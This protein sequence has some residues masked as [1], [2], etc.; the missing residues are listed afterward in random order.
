MAEQQSEESADRARSA[1]N[2]GK[3]P[4][5]N[6]TRNHC[7]AST[8][9]SA[10]ARSLR[11]LLN[12]LHQNIADEWQEGF[13]HVLQEEITRSFSKANPVQGS[14]RVVEPE[15]L[16]QENRLRKDGNQVR[17]IYYRK[18]GAPYDD[19]PLVLEIKVANLRVKRVLVDT[20]SSSDIISLQ[21]LQK[22]KHDA[23]A[24]EKVF[25]PLVG[26]EGSVVCPTASILL[27]VSIGTPPVTKE[28]VTRFTIVASLTSF[29]IILG[30]PAL[31]D[32]KAVIVPHLLQV[33][34]VGSNGRNGAL[35]GNQQLARDCY[36]TTLE[37]ASWG[38]SPKKNEKLKPLKSQ[39]KLKETPMAH[40]ADRRPKLVGEHYDIF[41][42]LTDPS[43]TVPI[44]IPPDDPMAAVLVQ[45]LRE[46]KEIFAF[47]VEEMPDINPAVAVHKLNVDSAMKPVRQK[48]RNHGEARNLAAAA[49]VQKLMDAS[50]IR[51]CQYPD[52]V[53]NVVLVPNPNG[54]WRMCVD[55]TDLNKACPKDSFPLPKIN[56]LVDSTV[57]HAMMS[58]IDAY[59]GFYQI[60]LWPEDQEK[61]SFVTEQ[62]L[63]CYKVMPFGLKNA[64]ATFQRLVNTVF[65][66]QLG[67]NI[68]AYIDDMIV[69]SKQ[70]TDHLGD[71]RETFETLRAYQMRLNP[72]KCIFGVTSGK[73]LSFLIDERGNE[74]NPDKVQAVITMTSPKI[75]K[76]VQRLTG[77]LAALR[78]FL[79]RAGDKCHYF[80]STI[81]KG[82]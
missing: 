22:L 32:L 54:T 3:L 58:F 38:A 61:T 71:L 12:D 81:K 16:R 79:S 20:G 25:M 31:N 70:R 56:R 26:F 76:D 17:L 63:Y 21:C 28:G 5:K 6:K 57:G 42:D 36:L 29:N 82:T 74:A 43:R 10:S 37:P 78:R 46:Y 67:R 11:Y 64:P 53:A 8:S 72:K 19:D 66:K 48:K 44:G 41:L 52:W 34:F 69:K 73:F 77:C 4:V 62:G 33:K 14:G 18:A 75:V 47:T 9:R 24:I 59:S 45:L 27:P 7:D 23:R 55:Y 39:R 49:E 60:P 13:Q 65:A 40:S 80:F 2:G 68:K 30:R 35:Y 50:L 51:P 1:T 15:G